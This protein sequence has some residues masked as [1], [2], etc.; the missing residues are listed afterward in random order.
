MPRPLLQPR[1]HFALT[2]ALDAQLSP[3]GRRV[4]YLQYRADAATDTYGVM[5]WIAST[6]SPPDAER[7]ICLGHGASPRWSPDGTRVAFLRSED[8]RQQI[9]LWEVA[10]GR[11]TRLTHAAEPCAGPAWSPDGRSIAFVSL[12]PD[13]SP[14]APEFTPNPLRNDAWAE[15]GR[16]TE[17]LVRRVEGVTD[18]VRAGHHQIFLV[19]TDGGD[20]RQLT[21]GPHDH[22]GPLAQTVKV[23]GIGRIAWAADGRSIVMSLNRDPVIPGAHAPARTLNCDVYDYAVDDG[24]VTRLT[25]FGGAACNAAVSPDGRWIAFVGFRNTRKAFHTQVMHVMDRHG[26]EPR[27]LT[28]PRG[29]EVHAAFEWTPDSAGLLALY[30]DG[31]AGCL[32]RVDLDGRWTTLSTAVGGSAGSGYVMWSKSVSVSRAG[33]IAFVESSAHGPDE[34]ALVSASGG[35][36]RR[37]TANNAALLA[38]R[39]LASVEEFWFETGGPSGRH[40]QGWLIRP[41]DF[42]PAR[43]Y[44]LLVWLHGGPYLAWGPQFALTPQLMAAR[45]YLVLLVNPRGSLGYGEEMLDAIEHCFPNDEDDAEIAAAVDATIALGQ[46]DERRLF[47]A[48]ESAG[49]T[50]AAWIIGRS[51]RFAAAAIAYPAI[52]WTSHALTVDRPDY[53]PYF[54]FPDAPWAPGVH[55]HYWQRS[56]LSRVGGVTTPTILLCGEND[57]RTPLAQSELYYTALKLRGVDAALVVFPD[58]NHAFEN[59]PSHWLEFIERMDGWFRRHTPA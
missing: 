28:H 30:V 56:P 2:H 14:T 20:V 8:S 59:H 26:G 29:L 40:L 32:A 54:W 48:G 11:C 17:R 16:C 45:G 18:R 6:A 37:I 38:A 46:V 19:S 12:V 50:L 39:T 34:V 57:R 43:S 42:D 31:G 55:E 21:D 35:A 13:P 23:V 33:E 51:A 25:D 22:G 47:I 15:A 7:Q 4:A 1:D 27:A 58:D 36:A 3:D 41:P 53:Y 9:F 49:G 5:L 10:T 44:P 24:R 52:D